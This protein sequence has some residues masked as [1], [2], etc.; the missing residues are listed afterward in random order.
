MI[1]KLIKY[2]TLLLTS[3]ILF[4]RSTIIG[5]L[6]GIWVYF[7]A[8]TEES[9]FSRMLTS[10]LYLFMASFLIFFRLLFRKTL[11]EDGDL[12]L[13]AMLFFFLGDL[14]CAVVAMFCAVPFFM[15]FNYTGSNY[16][17]QSH[18]AVDPRGLTYQIPGY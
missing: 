4:H 17:Q 11:K 18:T 10:D 13:K 9:A 12:D 15:M 7:G 1:N 8:E 6:C 2:F 5:V 3:G 14:V 16:T